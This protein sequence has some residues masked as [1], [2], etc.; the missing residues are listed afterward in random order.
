MSIITIVGARPNFLKLDPALPQT[1]IHTGQHYD[2]EMSDVFFRELKIKKPKYNLGCKGHEV[3]KMLDRLRPVLVQE[4][5]S[6]VL[7]FGD[8]NSSLAGAMAARY[9]KI[10]VA[11]IESGMRSYTEM[12]EELNRLVIDKISKIKLCVSESAM[13]NLEKEGLFDKHTYLVGDP[14]LDTLSRF[15][16]I[17]KTRDA[18]KYILVTIHREENTTN[19]FVKEFFNA[20]EGVDNKFI[21]PV[22]PRMKKIIKFL[23]GK[24]PKNVMTIE[25]QGY[26]KMISLIANAKKIITD[27]GG[28]QRE[29][30][31]LGVPVLVMRNETE[32]IELVQKGLIKL[33][34]LGSLKEDIFN[35][36]GKLVSAPQF[37]SNERIRKILYKYL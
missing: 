36:K 26:K 27:S 4:K 28:V 9:E 17:K 30:A 18:Q 35:F 7:V 1:I 37:G 6:F 22:H 34:S 33:C 12:P 32:W 3:G 29:G 21:M 23:K 31:W 24:M 11:H 13:A 2:N 25:P 5:P 10:P 14:M 8:T 16:P 19:D 15:L 20:L